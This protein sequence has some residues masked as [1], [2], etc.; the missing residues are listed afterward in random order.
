MNAITVI[1]I[2]FNN[3]SDLQKTCSSIDLQTVLPDE[4]L[5]IN[6]STNDDIAYWLNNHPQPTYRRWI[7]E[8][9][10]GIGD[11]FNKGITHASHPITHLL[12]AGDT[13]ATEKVIQ[14][15]KN[16][17]DQ[18]PTICWTSGNIRVVRSGA[19]IVIGKPF[20]AK[21]LYRGMR[22]VAH[23]TWFVKKEVYNRIGLFNNEI[24]IAMDYDLMCRISNEPYG[25]INETIAVFDDTGIS[26]T[27]YLQSLNDN[28]RIY[29]SHFG[30]SLQCRI[31]QF[32][33]RI[34]HWLL[35]TTF[36]KWLFQLKKALGLENL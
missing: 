23:P 12:H 35:L 22:S 27:N 10:K 31:W 8:R 24:K 18:H 25:Y 36:G 21:K 6:G 7:N 28:I 5:I 16:Y 26:T 15:V 1:S 4:H 14:M 19:E 29:E 17:Y 20:D 30:Y 2:C 11:A 33:L 34:L 3:L 13:Y 32:R 9:D